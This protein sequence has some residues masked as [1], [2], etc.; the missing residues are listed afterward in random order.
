MVEAR[1]HCE[2]SEAIH[3]VMRFVALAPHKEEGVAKT[4]I[5]SRAALDC[6]VA[7]LPAMTEGWAMKLFRLILD[8]AAV[9]ASAAWQ[10][11]ASLATANGGIE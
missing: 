11:S 6:R 3:G 8:N 10:S 2:C 4:Q 5:A 7:A 9:I 1:R